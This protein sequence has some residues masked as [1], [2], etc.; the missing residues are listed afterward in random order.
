M[1]R[2]LAKLFRKIGAT[3]FGD[4]EASP[5][6][7]TALRLDGGRVRRTPHLQPHQRIERRKVHA[8]ARQL[9]SECGMKPNKVFTA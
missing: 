6:A 9:E 2:L 7:N 4:G 1:T 8:V 3:V 5:S